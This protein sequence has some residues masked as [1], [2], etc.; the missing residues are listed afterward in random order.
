MVCSTT[1]SWGQVPTTL[2]PRMGGG[3]AVSS[4][5]R[6]LLCRILFLFMN[7]RAHDRLLGVAPCARH[8]RRRRS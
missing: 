6:S 3:V 1:S 8:L 4:T 2:I 5:A 7:A